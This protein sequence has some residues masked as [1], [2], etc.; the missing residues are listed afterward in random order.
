MDRDTIVDRH[1]FV[2]ASDSSLNACGEVDA[3]VAVVKEF[4]ND[5]ERMLAVPLAYHIFA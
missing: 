3:D 1:T 4:Q 2:K 5:W